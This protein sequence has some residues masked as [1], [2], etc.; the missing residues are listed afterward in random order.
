MVL[1]TFNRIVEN[2]WQTRLSLRG[3]HVVRAKLGA[4]EGINS[5]LEHVIEHAG[6][7]FFEQL[8]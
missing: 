8:V 3:S 4:K 7:H 1:V 6:D 2:Y 5:Q